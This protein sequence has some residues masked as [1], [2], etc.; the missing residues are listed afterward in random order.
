M[1]VQKMWN[2]IFQSKTWFI[3]PTWRCNL[4][5]IM[6]FTKSPKKRLVELEISN[7]LDIL[8]FG[9]NFTKH[10]DIGGGEPFLKRG[11]ENLL[12]FI[13]ESGC[14]STVTTNGTMIDTFLRT[15]KLNASRIEVSIESFRDSVHNFIRPFVG[16]GTSFRQ[17]MNGLKALVNL[18]QK[19]KLDAKIGV[20]QVM[21]KNNMRDF[22]LLVKKLGE[23]GI[24][25]LYSQPLDL[26]GLGKKLLS[27]LPSPIDY[28]DVILDTIHTLK[29][30]SNISIKEISIYLPHPYY[31]FLATIF[32]KNTLIINDTILNVDM[33]NCNCKQYDGMLAI[34]PDGSING[35]YAQMN[36]LDLSAGYIID[37]VAK[38]Q[39]FQ[40]AIKKARERYI[41]LIKSE[42]FECKTCKYYWSCK[43]GCRANA[44]SY[45]GSL[46][47]R[48]PR[49]PGENY[50]IP[51][52]LK[53]K[54]YFILDKI[55]TQQIVWGGL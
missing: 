21:L 39:E 36:M 48:D 37:Y 45:F 15:H 6:C 22:P 42:Q 30:I 10:F 20:A 5:C 38:P 19:G 11:I 26:I 41:Q 16:E 52:D 43:G 25:Y 34:G 12:N 7:W 28:L 31:P 29:T 55:D 13:S 14:Y 17:A 32:K 23:L 18:K 3:F 50:I 46:Y 49:C 1:G 2:N 47:K 4:N 9:C 44:L 8:E 27:W 54:A 53:E 35:C 40:E 24:D 51:E 33:I